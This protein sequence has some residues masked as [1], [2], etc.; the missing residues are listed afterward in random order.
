MVIGCNLQSNSK[1][2]PILHWQRDRGSEYC[3]RKVS[4]VTSTGVW[5]CVIISVGPSVETSHIPK[6]YF[7]PAGL[8]WA[9]GVRAARSWAAG[10]VPGQGYGQAGCQGWAAR[11]TWA[12]LETQPFTPTHPPVSRHNHQSVYQ[13][14][15]AVSYTQPSHCNP[16]HL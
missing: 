14:L 15:R 6:V 1:S 8:G 11:G 2:K 9:A 4:L 13:I 7:H 10:P 5:R 16:T 3:L 12:Q